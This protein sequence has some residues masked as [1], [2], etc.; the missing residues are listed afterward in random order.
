MK[1]A[2]ARWIEHQWSKPNAPV[3]HVLTWPLQFFFKHL[4]YA[5]RLYFKT[6][7]QGPQCPVIVVGNIH[8]GGMGKSP[9]VQSLAI[10]LAQQQLA[11]GILLRGYQGQHTQTILLT[12]NTTALDVGDE[13]VMHFQR[14]QAAAQQQ[15]IITPLVMVDA[16]R[17]R[18]AFAL[19]RLKVDVII[20]DDG[21]QHYK[22]ARDFEVVMMDSQQRPGQSHLLPTGSL[23]EPI[24]RLNDVDLV[25]TQG[26]LHKDWFDQVPDLDAKHWLYTTQ[27]DLPVEIDFTAKTELACPLQPCQ[28]HVI[29]A[30]ARPQRVF[31]GLQDQGFTVI[32]HVF[33][34]HYQFLKQDII[35]F[36]A[37]DGPLVVT[38]KDLV[39]I[40]P[41]VEQCLIN[42]SVKT[43]E[44]RSR[45]YLIPF[46]A[47]LNPDMVQQMY[48]T[49]LCRATFRLF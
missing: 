6:K 29:S 44:V 27:M 13:A 36:L 1:L 38:A 32:K 12:S 34:D 30:I 17:V 41:L 21:L 22:L 20:C 37:L 46:Q 16:H 45:L 25:L 7:A 47:I 24:T 35:D 49:A 5:R 43:A 15:A 18:G 33:M 3:W 23:R 42:G 2:I 26:P 9:V 11:V 31:Q 10:A 19:E 28:I 8:V 40:K 48:S 39:K 4:S 14:F